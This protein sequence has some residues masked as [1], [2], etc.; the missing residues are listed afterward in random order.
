MGDHAMAKTIGGDPAVSIRMQAV[1]KLNDREYRRQKPDLVKELGPALLDAD[2]TKLREQMKADEA[3]GEPDLLELRQLPLEEPVD[4]RALLSRLEKVLRKHLVLGDDFIYVIALWVVFA[5]AH[6]AFDTSPFL[7][8][9]SPMKRCGK[10]RLVRVL[11]KLVPDPLSTSNVTPAG[12]FTATDSGHALLIDEGDT[13]LDDDKQMRGTLNG[14]HTRDGAFVRRSGKQLST[15]APKVFAMISVGLHATLLDRSIRIELQRKAPGREVALVPQGPGAYLNLHRSCRRWA[16]D[17][18][19][20]LRKAKP[21]IVNMLNDRERDNW[22]PLFAIAEACGGDWPVR[23]RNAA[24]HLH[25]PED[26]DEVELLLRDLKKLFDHHD[27]RHLFTREIIKHLTAIAHRPWADFDRGRPL[28]DRALAK[29]LNQR[30]KIRPSQVKVGDRRANGYRRDQFNA[31]FANLYPE[32]SVTSAQ[33]GHDH[34]EGS[35]GAEAI[36]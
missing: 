21:Q 5:H 8:I 3:D 13:F 27:G 30:F 1:A 31:A 34:T 19:G 12:V 4:G 2:R 10:T 26:E 15:Y 29:L 7:V 16:L 33:R 11:G 24:R 6:D 32:P 18:L 28:N 14:S 9:T 25:V 20:V 35:E 22:K 36:S 23:A 17:N